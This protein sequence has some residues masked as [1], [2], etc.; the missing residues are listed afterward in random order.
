MKRNGKRNLFKGSMSLIAFGGWTLLIKGID[1]QP[2]GQNGTDIGFATFNTW[3]H[4]LLDV[5]MAVYILTDWLGLVPIFVCMIFAV[6]GFVQL[7]GRR[8]I[9]KVDYDI[10]LLGIYY[11]IVIG[12]YLIFEMFPINYRPVLID[13]VMEA[14][15]PSSTTL[16]VLCVMP[17]LV[18][19]AE[20]RWQSKVC[21]RILRILV[22]CFSV[23]MVVGR[24][25]S[26]VHWFTDIVGSILLSEGLFGIYKGVVILRKQERKLS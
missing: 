5:N 10:L 8:S 18:E 11:I 6:V 7:I 16:L 25:V 14:S 24:L 22:I 13:G 19:Q 17:T 3:F 9:L 21:K 4:R 12:S 23:F 15:Y 2:L 1:V 20:R 26:G